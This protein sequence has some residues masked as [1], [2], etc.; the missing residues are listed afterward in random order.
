[1]VQFF[2]PPPRYTSDGRPPWCARRWPLVVR[3][4]ADPKSGGAVAAAPRSECA[5]TVAL[6]SEG[7]TT[8]APWSGDT[9]AVGPRW[10]DGSDSSI[11]RHND[12]GPPIQLHGGDNSSIW[13]CNDSGSL[14]WSLEA[15]RRWLPIGVAATAPQR[16]AWFAIHTTGPVT[17][18]NLARFVH[19]PVSGGE[20]Q[21]RG[22]S[23]ASGD[24]VFMRLCI[25]IL[26]QRQYV[27]TTYI[28]VHGSPSIYCLLMIFLFTFYANVYWFYALS[29][30]LTQCVYWVP[31]IYV[32]CIS[33][34]THSYTQWN[35][36]SQKK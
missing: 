20:S 29:H 16:R 32:I 28:S 9:A 3:P 2:T 17:S 34:T 35:K 4:T 7:A 15:R 24:P 8:V 12:S 21:R 11:R 18:S 25:H 26:Y 22:G 33:F 6:R 27:F 1:M 5:T 13:R 14:I 23:S 19:P 36:K 10:C 30:Y 31:T